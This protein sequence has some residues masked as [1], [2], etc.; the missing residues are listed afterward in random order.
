MIK[1][2]ALDWDKDTRAEKDEF[3]DLTG[4][5]CSRKNTW[6]DSHYWDIFKPYI[7]KTEFLTL[8]LDLYFT[9]QNI[10]LLKYFRNSDEID[11]KLGYK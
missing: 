10:Y 3:A 11:Y 8:L 6:K 5:L 4:N 2:R 1:I 9:P 7:H